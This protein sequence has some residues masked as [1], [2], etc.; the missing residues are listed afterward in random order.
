[1][2][3]VIQGLE[4]RSYQD[5]SVRMQVFARKSFVVQNRDIIQARVPIA[6]LPALA[7]APIVVQQHD[8]VNDS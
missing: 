3:F 4:S 6:L 7:S 8:V 2:P 5:D 1:M